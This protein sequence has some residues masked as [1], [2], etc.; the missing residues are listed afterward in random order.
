MAFD[1]N[2]LTAEEVA[3]MLGVSRNTIYNM[4]REG[5]LASYN[6]G[7]KLRFTEEDVTA[8]IAQARNSP[9]DASASQPTPRTATAAHVQTARSA[10]RPETGQQGTFR[11]AGDDVIADVLANYLSGAGL[12]VQ[13]IYENSYDSLVDMYL[14]GVEAALVQQYD[15]RTQ[16]YNV[17]SAQRIIP[18]TPM[19]VIHVVKRWQ[20][21][22]VAKGNPKRIRRWSDFLRDDVTMVNGPKGSGSRILLDEKLLELEAGVARPHGYEREAVSPLAMGAAIAQGRADVGLGSERVYHQVDGLDFVPLQQENLDLVLL[23]TERTM[24]A[25]YY[26]KNLTRSEGFETELSSIVGYSA[27]NTGEVAYEV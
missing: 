19:V 6:V 9:P 10:F 5:T 18:G 1:M 24:R 4:A 2:A 27:V 15:H 14:N 8:F 20:G 17:A 7:R 22:L 23:K 16:S 21:L 3:K 11:V 12:P 13:R 25:V 26:C